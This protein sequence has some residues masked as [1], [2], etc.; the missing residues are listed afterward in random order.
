ML[1]RLSDE[2]DA[3]VNIWEEPRKEGESALTCVE[4]RSHGSVNTMIAGTVNQLVCWLTDP[5]QG[6]TILSTSSITF[7]RYPF[8]TDFLSYVSRIYEP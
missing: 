4:E 7:L 8:P 3:D 1:I 5:T 6:F 2:E